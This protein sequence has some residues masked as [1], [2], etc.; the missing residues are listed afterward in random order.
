VILYR[1]A[2]TIER[3]PDVI[4]PYL[5]DPALQAKWTDSP[6]SP[7]DGGMIGL[8]SLVERTLRAGPR[9][10]HLV[11]LLTT[12]EPNRR[13]QFETSEGPVLWEAEY[14]LEPTGDATIVRQEGRLTFQG[15]WRAVEPLVGEGIKKDEA[16]ELERLKEVVEAA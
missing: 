7:K 10:A 8:R 12:I 3:A 14:L 13:L 15:T 2:V 4:F 11:L 16:R 1:S 6:M 5:T 9:T